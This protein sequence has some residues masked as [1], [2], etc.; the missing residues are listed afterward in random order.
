V[1]RQLS[2]DSGGLGEPLFKASS[3][4]A[5]SAPRINPDTGG[6]GAILWHRMNFRSPKGSLRIR[7]QCPRGIPRLIIFHLPFLERPVQRKFGQI[8]IPLISN[9]DVIAF[10]VEEYEFLFYYFWN[11]SQ[12]IPTRRRDSLYN[13]SKSGLMSCYAAVLNRWTEGARLN[14]LLPTSWYR[15]SI[16]SIFRLS[17]GSMKSATAVA[18]LENGEGLKI[19]VHYIGPL[20]L[21]SRRWL[22]IE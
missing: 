11:E 16:I 13:D 15:R 17:A 7:F 8:P 14:R 3:D 19:E 2:A 1:V 20:N 18:Y 21:T 22:R 12:W 10:P 6:Q 4:Q 5:S 9:L